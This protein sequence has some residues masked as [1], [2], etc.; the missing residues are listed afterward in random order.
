M[1]LKVWMI[2]CGPWYW[3]MNSAPT[4][5][6]I[7][8]RIPEDFH[9]YSD[10]TLCLGAPLAVNM[11]FA[12]RPTL[13]A[14]IKIGDALHHVMRCAKAPSFKKRYFHSRGCACP[15]CGSKDI[16]S[17]PVEADGMVGWATVECPK[18]GHTWQ[19]VWT[20]IDIT[21]VR[22]ADGREKGDT[23]AKGANS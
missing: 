17:G 22:D 16:M 20:V 13:S 1:C 3:P 10:M 8:G 12:E 6:E 14:Y 15:F 19:D 7:G 5:T 21:E 18:C 11:I 9:K 4:A 2:V 23:D